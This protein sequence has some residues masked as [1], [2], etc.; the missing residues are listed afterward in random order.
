MELFFFSLSSL[1]AQMPF[2]AIRLGVSGNAFNNNVSTI[3]SIATLKD[4]PWITFFHRQGS[5]E[6]PYN[7]GHFTVDISTDGGETWIVDNSEFPA[8]GNFNPQGNSQVQC[9][10][11]LPQ[12]ILYN[13]EE[14]QDICNLQLIWV[15]AGHYS[16]SL[17]GSFP[18]GNFFY[19]LVNGINPNCTQPYNE[20]VKN[21]LPRENY[22]YTTGLSKGKNGEFW[23]V[24]NQYSYNSQFFMDKIFLWKS[25]IENYEWKIYDTLTFNPKR[26]SDLNYRVSKPNLAFSEDGKYGWIIVSGIQE[27]PPPYQHQ[28]FYWKTHNYGLTWDQGIIDIAHYQPL[29]DT[30]TTLIP[31]ELNTTQIDTFLGKP[32]PLDFD[33]VVDKNGNPHI[34]C[35]FFNMTDSASLRLII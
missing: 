10:G 14:N 9:M 8:F 20:I 19:G 21:R 23:T 13:P 11:R 4:K 28:L 2:Q 32:Y 1:I 35:S 29:I 6:L 15:S 26:A 3:H 33:L 34:V 5:I 25:N 30:L 18:W 31:N 24:G 16:N 12:A 17:I 22:L 27:G 7:H